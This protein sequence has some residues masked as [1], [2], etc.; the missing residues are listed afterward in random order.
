[1]KKVLY[2]LAAFS[3]VFVAC[4]KQEIVPEEGTSQEGEL[5]TVTIK[6]SNGDA[7]TKA[8]ISDGLA[9]TWTI[10]DQIAV[11]TDAGRFYTSDALTT[12]GTTA[13]FTVSLSGNRN[14]YAVY[15][16]SVAKSWSESTL[17]LTLPSEYDLTKVFGTESPLPMIAANISEALSFYHVT[18]L[19]RL[20]IT[21]IPTGTNKIKLD[22]NG[23]K[24][25]GDF[26]I[27]S[28]SAGS[29]SIGS[30]PGTKGTNDIIWITGITGTADLTVNIPLPTGATYSD[31]VVSAWNNDVALKGHVEA[32]SYSAT[33]AYGKKLSVALDLGAF[34]VASGKYAVFAPGN[35]QYQASTGKWRFAE[36]QWTYIGDAAGNNTVSG[37]DTQEAWIDLFGWGTSGWAS[38]GW[39]CYQPWSTDQT[40]SN[41]GPELPLNLTGDYAK[42]DWGVNN[43]IGAYAAG[44]WRTPTSGSGGE[45]QWM[46]GGHSGDDIPGDNIRASSTVSGVTNARYAYAYLFG[47]IHGLILFP[48]V[49][50]HPDGVPVLSTSIN[51]FDTTVD[52]VYNTEL[53]ISLYTANQ[54]TVDQWGKMEAAGAVF[55]PIAGR[56]KGTVIDQLG[57]TGRYWSSINANATNSYVLYIYK[58]IST[59]GKE[60][61]AI[62]TKNHWSKYGGFAV[63]L[64][65]DLN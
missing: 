54:Y 15:P 3:F 40:A 18:G 52:G 53:A 43:A 63:R 24:V 49:Y 25:S 12:G 62:G 22:F 47:S 61:V 35:L 9:F 50:S 1:M 30:V 23:K 2:T 26:T 20:T 13:D 27:S 6:A 58:D 28:P 32:F 14:G 41:Y 21:N 60:Q 64:I 59:S 5:T 29:S 65:R 44:T 38:G 34:S 31:L 37:R 46:L 8:A 45:F 16:A 17:T 11:H 33:R 56:R 51:V 57:Q 42:G 36:Y 4:N 48:D 39:T 10:G 19:L 7:D 55:L